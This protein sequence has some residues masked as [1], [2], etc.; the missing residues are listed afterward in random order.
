MQIRWGHFAIFVILASLDNAAAGILPPLY[1]IISRELN[2]SE[3]SLGIVTAVYVIIIAI[4][5]IAWGYQ[6]DR[7]SRKPLLLAGTA[8]WTAAMIATSFSTTF[9][10][11]LLFQSITAVGV[12]A[13]S[14]IGFSVVSDVVP[15]HRRGFALSLWSISQGLG[16]AFG[17]LLASTSGAFDWRSPFLIVAG[18]GLFFGV[19]YTFIPEPKRGAAEPELRPLFEAG[20][21][22]TNRIDRQAIKQILTQASTRW[23]LIQAFF[24][25]FAFGASVWIPRWAIA[26][27]EAQ[28]FD[29]ESATVIGNGI[30]LLFSIGSVASIYAGHLG[31]Q[32]EKRYAKGRPYMAMIGSMASAP[33]FIILFFMPLQGVTPPDTFTL[34]SS[35]IWIIES[36]LQNPLLIVAFFLATVGN[37]LLAADLPN[38]AAMITNLNLP[39]HRGTAIGISRLFRAAGNA[40][41][42][43]TAGFLFS[44][45]QNIYSETDA[46][47]VGLAVFQG[48]TIVSA[49]CYWFIQNTIRDDS[50]QI[51]KFLKAH[52]QNQL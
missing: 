35:L 43:A 7:F 30:V 45:L 20:L 37:I 29:L 15:A 12:G 5:S 24:Y 49:G 10:T 31:D 50:I 9:S 17:A 32:L 21:N 16:A 52:A 38:W 44:W 19:L 1:A 28:G 46:F 6:G 41:G 22:Y 33:F 14:S 27:V 51:T 48:V 2:A 18:L 11:F 40:L 3:T 8:V 23:L 36:F 42:I 4:S 26:R 39:E 47:A 34:A 13:V 25:S